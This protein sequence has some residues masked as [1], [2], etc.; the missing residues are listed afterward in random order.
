MIVILCQRYAHKQALSS[1][2]HW[3]GATT[4]K[5]YIL[6]MPIQIIFDAPHSLPLLPLQRPQLRDPLVPLTI[7]MSTFAYA[8]SVLAVYS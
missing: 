1:V 3:I 7:L 4:A 2:Y 5:T 6:A 8:E